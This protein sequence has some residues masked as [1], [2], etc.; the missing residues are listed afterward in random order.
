MKILDVN[1]HLDSWRTGTRDGIMVQLFNNKLTDVVPA[2]ADK[3][4][5]FDYPLNKTI[6]LDPSFPALPTVEDFINFVVNS[7]RD[8]YKNEPNNIWGHGFG[9]LFLEGVSL[10]NDGKIELNMGS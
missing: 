8:I 4:V 3:F 7:Y 1:V 10:R 5:R 6:K 9:D 2:L